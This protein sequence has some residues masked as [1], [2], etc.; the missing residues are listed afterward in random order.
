MQAKTLIVLGCT[1]HYYNFPVCI[2]RA[3]NFLPELLVLLIPNI[4]ILLHTYYNTNII[5]NNR[6]YIICHML[7]SQIN[8]TFS[9]NRAITGPAIFTNQLDL[10]SWYTNY[11]PYFNDTSQVLRWPFIYYKYVSVSDLQLTMKS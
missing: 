10:C 3:I 2:T 8:I 11:P 1:L 7:Y 9:G 4:T 6:N 5:V